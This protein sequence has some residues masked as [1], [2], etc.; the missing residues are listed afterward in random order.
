M[1]GLF[2]DDMAHASTCPKLKKQFLQEYKKDFDITEEDIMSTF[3]G[4]EVEQSKDSI[5]L[6]LDTYIQETLDEYKSIFKKFLKP[7]NVP[8]QPGVMLD[9]QDCPETPDL[10]EQKVYR[11]HGRVVMADIPCSPGG[12]RCGFD[13]R[14]PRRTKRAFFPPLA[15]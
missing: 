8:M 14:Q 10:R 12:G 7:K 1:H 4:M 5:K 15:I 6:H 13:P 9:N 11:N 3:L 2:V